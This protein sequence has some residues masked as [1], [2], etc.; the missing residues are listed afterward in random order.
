MILNIWFDENF[1]KQLYETESSD[2]DSDVESDDDEYENERRKEERARKPKRKKVSSSE[3]GKE[4]QLQDDMIEAEKIK[5][6]QY[7]GFIKIK[8][9]L[10]NTKKSMR[11]SSP[12]N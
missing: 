12:F 7:D 9:K 11:S 6:F 3:S 4:S 1:G 2:S 5:D 10:P 8:T